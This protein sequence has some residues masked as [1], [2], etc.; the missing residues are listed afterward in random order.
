MAAESFPGDDAAAPVF[1]PFDMRGGKA[2]YLACYRD[3]WRIAHGSLSGFDENACWNG[4]RTRAAESPESVMEMRRNGEFAGILAL[5][6]RRGAWRGYGWIAFFYV[7]PPL[8]GRG[9]GRAMLDRAEEHFAALG[10]RAVRLTV[11]PGNPALGFYERTGFVR[12]GT[13]PGALE[14]LYVME[15]KL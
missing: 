13:E 2:R 3:A 5:D 14:P 12:A 15:K 9:L 11:A 6:D 10:R 4:A 7:A 1:V 8:R